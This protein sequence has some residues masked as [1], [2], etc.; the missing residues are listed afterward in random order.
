[1]VPSLAG[2]ATNFYN[3]PWKSTDLSAPIFISIGRA[4]HLASVVT[5]V[6]GGGSIFL[7]HP[8]L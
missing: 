4:S 5:K 7:N 6:I 1:M 3:A 2:W 8:A